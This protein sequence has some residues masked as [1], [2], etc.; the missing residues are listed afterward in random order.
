[1]WKSIKLQEQYNSNGG[2]LLSRRK[3]VKMVKEHLKEEII[4]FWSRGQTSLL[5]FDF[6]SYSQLMLMQRCESSPYE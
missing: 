5:V 4:V 3:L 6:D 1:M 2:V